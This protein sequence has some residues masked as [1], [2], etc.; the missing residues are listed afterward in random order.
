MQI[1]WFPSTA[2]PDT[3][4][5]TFALFKMYWFPWGFSYSSW[6]TEDEPVVDDPRLDTYNVDEK[7]DKLFKFVN[8]YSPY[9]QGNHVFVPWGEDFC[10]ENAFA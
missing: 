6:D 2:L 9:F 4:I 3:S 7:A 5:F 8:D 10:Y 1:N